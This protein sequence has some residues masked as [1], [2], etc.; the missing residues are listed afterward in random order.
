MDIF[1]IALKSFIIAV[2]I[3]FLFVLA[4]FCR[5]YRT[6]SQWLVQVQ[7]IYQL[8]QPKEGDKEEEGDK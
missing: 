8:V 1:K 6:A 7:P 3:K 2:D 4:D 5:L